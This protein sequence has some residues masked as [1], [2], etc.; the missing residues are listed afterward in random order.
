LHGIHAIAFLFYEYQPRP[1]SLCPFIPQPIGSGLAKNV[2]SAASRLICNH[3]RSLV[4]SETY[5]LK[6]LSPHY[7]SYVCKFRIFQKFSAA[8]KI[9]RVAAGDDN[10]VERD[11]LPSRSS[12]RFWWI[13]ISARLRAV[14]YGAAVFALA[15]LR[16][17]TGG[18]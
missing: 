10:D 4:L 9:R 15:A 13:I 7:S 18:R 12:K 5:R 6:L 11:G 1:Y 3:S 8:A 17:K 14:R 16:A 2:A